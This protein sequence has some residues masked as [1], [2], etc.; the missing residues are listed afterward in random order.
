MLLSVPTAKI[1]AQYPLMVFE[2]IDPAH[3]DK[4]SF[5]SLAE[6]GLAHVDHA[7]YVVKWHVLYPS[8]GQVYAT[9]TANKVGSFLVVV[10]LFFWFLFCFSFRVFFLVSFLSFWL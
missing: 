9:T 6:E 10:S 8:P 1:L 7:E 5:S 3:H 2:E 4:V